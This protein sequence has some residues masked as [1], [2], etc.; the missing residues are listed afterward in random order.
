MAA[1]H[2]RDSSKINSKYY[3]PDKYKTTRYS[4][5]D[6]KH[7]RRHRG[8]GGT[9]S[10]SFTLVHITWDCVNTDIDTMY[11]SNET[12]YHLHANVIDSCM[13]IIAG[14]PVLDETTSSRPD[15]SQWVTPVTPSFA[16]ASSVCAQPCT[17]CTPFVMQ[18]YVLVDDE[19]IWSPS[20]PANSQTSHRLMS[21]PSSRK[22]NYRMPLRT[23]PKA[24]TLLPDKIIA[25]LTNLLRPICQAKKVSLN[26]PS[27]SG[28]IN[29][30]IW[31]SNH[32][33]KCCSNLCDQLVAC[34]NIVFGSAH[35]FCASV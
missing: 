35:K 2:E 22:A 10:P 32:F 30:I 34:E 24:E 25:R 14:R 18:G 11:R 23:T 7:H 29:L 5:K 8:H 31:W 16:K 21:L 6:S 27:R 20:C 12:L 17:T 1:F 26:S 28:F 15:L 4:D 19:K 3:K 9:T 13:D 33:A